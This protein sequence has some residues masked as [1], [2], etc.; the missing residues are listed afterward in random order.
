MRP[1]PLLLPVLATGCITR[2]M[3][4]RDDFSDETPERALERTIDRLDEAYSFT[5]WKGL[6]WDRIHQDLDDQLHDTDDPDLVFR[7]LVAAIPDGHV[8][9]WN[10][11]PDRNLCPEAE[12]DLGL[13]FGWTEDG[14]VVVVFV[15]PSGA[16]AAGVQVRDVVVAV[17][18]Q[19]P[20]DALSAMPLH[21]SP[22]GLATP[23]R[24]R[25]VALRLL[26]RAAAEETRAF[27]L[28]REEAGGRVTEHTVDLTGVVD[29][30]GPAV[31][32]GLK[33]AS[34]RVS[35]RMWRPGVGYLALGW[36]D[37]VLSERAVRREVRRLWDDGARVL[38]LDM[39]NNDGGTDQ[40]AANIA[41]VFTDRTWFYETITMFDRSTGQQ[42]TVS[43][44]WVEPQPVLWDLPV[45][46]LVNGNTVSSGEGIAMML[47]RFETVEVVG[48]EGTAASFGSAGSTTFLPG[49]WTLSWPAGRSL[50]RQGRIQ[51]DSDHTGEGG[52]QPTLLVP[53]TVDHLVADAA[54]PVGFL[55]DEA[56]DR[57][58][59]GW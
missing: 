40:T 39:R 37:T 6:D 20:V 8:S 30:S 26:G 11:D 19:D 43:D 33:A 28:A 38:V 24:R 44:V 31:A 10:D 18:Q 14:D 17:D 27:T 49:G 36:E 50:D 56:L 9:L 41:G 3:P 21:C 32:L 23:A 22:K 53:S 55:V 12:A 16:A 13:R 2:L 59:G 48:L 46:A 1:V 35:A 34:E 5:R 54:D 57:L 7:S 29:G 15:D 47:R 25:H 58:A 42:A 52:V 45:V 4:L 51:L